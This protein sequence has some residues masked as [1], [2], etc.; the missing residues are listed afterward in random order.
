VVIWFGRHAIVVGRDVP[1]GGRASKRSLCRAG[2][3]TD[4]HELAKHGDPF[5]FA[6]H[7]PWLLIQLL[8]L[9]AIQRKHVSPNVARFLVNMNRVAATEAMPSGPSGLTPQ[10]CPLP[11]QAPVTVPAFATVRAS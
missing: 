2:A 7:H 4:V 11:P 10:R 8:S 6:H 1:I 3:P 5:I 9:G